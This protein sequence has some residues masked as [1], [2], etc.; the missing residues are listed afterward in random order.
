MDKISITALL[1]VH[2]SELGFQEESA[3][4]KKKSGIGG[5]KG[6]WILYCWT[7]LFQEINL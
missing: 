1:E 3:G 6:S 4:I 5:G 7:R 2:L